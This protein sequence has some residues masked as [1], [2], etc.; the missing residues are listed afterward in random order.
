MDIDTHFFTITEM[1]ELCRTNVATVRHW[2]KIGFGP[3]GV[4]VGR[5]VLYPRPAVLAWFQELARQAG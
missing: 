4:R 5:R 1:A 3:R 2:R